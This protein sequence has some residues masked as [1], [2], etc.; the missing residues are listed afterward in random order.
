MMWHSTNDTSNLG[1]AITSK[2]CYNCAV[3]PL[4]TFTIQNCTDES[5][6]SCTTDLSLCAAPS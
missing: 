6:S 4:P 5:F 1:A 2:V 3:A